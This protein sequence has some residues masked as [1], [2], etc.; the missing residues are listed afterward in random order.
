MVGQAEF[1]GGLVHHSEPSSLMGD[2]MLWKNTTKKKREYWYF[3]GIRTKKPN[4]INN[5]NKIK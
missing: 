5:N 4:I 2:K 1:T 3:R